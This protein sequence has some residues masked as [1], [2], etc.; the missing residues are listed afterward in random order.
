MS[1]YSYFK[2]C[3]KDIRNKWLAR[4]FSELSEMV[5]F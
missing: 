2:Y 5:S 3:K 1:A 4:P